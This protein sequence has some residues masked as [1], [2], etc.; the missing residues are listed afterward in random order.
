[1][2]KIQYQR[3]FGKVIIQ[4]N[5]FNNLLNKNL[6]KD[7]EFEEV[8]FMTNE[9]IQEF[10]NALLELNNNESIGYNELLKLREEQSV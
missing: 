8:A 3:N 4:E 6:T 7:V 5:L 9:E 10:D 2:I 1:M